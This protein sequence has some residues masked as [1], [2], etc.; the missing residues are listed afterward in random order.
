MLKIVLLLAI[1]AGTFV[2][3]G[4]FGAP[5]GTTQAV[6]SSAVTPIM[7]GAMFVLGAVLF[8]KPKA[9]NENAPTEKKDYGAGRRK[10]K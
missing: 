8:K 9:Q 7:L 6:G 1:L 3:E 10:R 2:V 5:E 4:M